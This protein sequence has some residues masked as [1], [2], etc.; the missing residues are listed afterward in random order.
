MHTAC[1]NFSVCRESVTVAV[2]FPLFLVAVP[3]LLVLALL[4]RCCRH[5]LTTGFII[6]VFF[7]LVVVVV[8][9]VV[10]V[11]CFVIVVCFNVET[12]KRFGPISLLGK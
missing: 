9:V 1:F 5:A 11:V 8:I 7:L 6:F 3:R 2:L 12:G 4:H 10:V